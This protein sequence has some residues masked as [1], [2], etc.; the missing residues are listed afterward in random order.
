MLQSHVC[1]VLCEM[2][3]LKLCISDFFVQS[4]N[5]CYMCGMAKVNPS[6]SVTLAGINLVLL[7][8]NATLEI[9]V[10]EYYH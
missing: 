9:S 3:D 8:N 10:K 2:M 7:L 1:L 4:Y 6:T 5:G